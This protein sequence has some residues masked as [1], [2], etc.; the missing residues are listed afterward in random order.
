[1]I[2]IRLCFI[3]VLDAE[4]MQAFT[5]ATDLGASGVFLHRCS[6]SGQ[7]QDESKQVHA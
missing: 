6:A 7:S 4:Q 1:M 2:T 3:M 5:R